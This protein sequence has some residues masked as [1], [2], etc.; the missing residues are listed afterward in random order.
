MNAD[1]HSLR[2]VTDWAAAGESS[3]ER[4]QVRILVAHENAPVRKLIKSILRNLGFST[5]QESTTTANLLATLG[6]DPVQILICGGERASQEGWKWVETLHSGSEPGEETSVVIVSS[7][8]D[9]ETIL[10]AVHAGV[11]E[12]IVLPFSAL[13]FEERINT[14]VRKKKLDC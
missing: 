8:S 3:P 14:L 7:V 12:Y 10:E 5:I 13:L 9:K 4:K 1:S 11:D 6:K 2:T